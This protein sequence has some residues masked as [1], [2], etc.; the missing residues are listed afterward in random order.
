MIHKGVITM[1]AV[2]ALGSALALADSQADRPF[3]LNPAQ[4]RVVDFNGAFAVFEENKIDPDSTKAGRELLF[5][6]MK[7]MLAAS[8]IQS[9]AV[10]KTQVADPPDGIPISAA[11]TSLHASDLDQAALFRLLLNSGAPSADVKVSRNKSGPESIDR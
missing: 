10:L 7:R 8:E 9:T 3:N 5:A 6:G 4:P 11:D 1:A 2:A